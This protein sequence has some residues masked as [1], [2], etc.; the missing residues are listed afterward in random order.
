MVVSKQKIH[1]CTHTHT[2]T[3]IKYNTNI[4]Y[5]KIK[6]LE[7]ISVLCEGSLSSKDKSQNKIQMYTYN[8]R[9]NTK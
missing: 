2:N 4:K 6:N 3:Y 1:I 9:A 7:F 5:K 8:M